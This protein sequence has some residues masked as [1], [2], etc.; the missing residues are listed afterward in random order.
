MSVVQCTKLMT[1]ERWRKIKGNPGYEVSDFGRVRSFWTKGRY[2]VIGTVPTIRKTKPTRDGHLQVSFKVRR[3]RTY[4]YVHRLVL[5][6]FVGPC[7]DG[8]EA[9][10]ADDDPANNNLANLSW[11]TR[12]KNMEDRERNGRVLKGERVGNSKLKDKDAIRIRQRVANGERCCS[13]HK[14]YPYVTNGAILAVISGRNFKH[15]LGKVLSVVDEGTVLPVT[16]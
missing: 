10:H 6:A 13:I 12:Y 5:E 3:Q 11:G 9:C 4:A 14:D 2:A 7:P 8:M 1:K 16:R 15:L